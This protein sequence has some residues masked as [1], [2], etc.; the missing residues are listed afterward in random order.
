MDL[1]SKNQIPFSCHVTSNASLINEA[2]IKKMTEISLNSFQI[3]IDGS[4]NRHNK[5]RN[6]KGNP[7]FDLIMSNIF[8]I[9]DLISN[10][11]IILRINYDEQTLKDESLKNVFRNIPEK[12][13][14]FIRIDFQRV[15]QT[16]KEGKEENILR[17]EYIN[18]CR[19][20]GFTIHELTNA[21]SLSGSKHYKCY[22]DRKY[23]AEINYDGKI[24]SCTAEGYTDFFQFGTLKDNGE[25]E[26]K[27][28]Q[29][30]RKLAKD[31]FENEMCLACKYLPVC[32]GPCSKKIMYTPKEHLKNICVL[33]NIEITP[34]TMVIDLYKRRIKSSNR[35]SE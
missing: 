14:K 26:Y 3:T 31:P 18:L 5:I 32:W 19:D 12:Y 15:W 25:I 30:I 35:D 13:R 29:L 28:E 11:S 7:S 33:K 27:E 9:C 23:H 24:Y 6:S 1:C 2:M 10:P 22:A 4:P 8:I 20:L 21:L 34:E 16:V 17:I